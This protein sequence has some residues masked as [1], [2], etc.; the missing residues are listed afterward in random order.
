M[1]YA[2]LGSYLQDLGV[3]KGVRT[4]KGTK[5]FEKIQIIHEDFRES[6]EGMSYESVGRVLMALIAYAND[7]DVS[8]ILGDDVQAKTLFPTIKKHVERNEGYRSKCAENGKKG[9]APF[10]NQNATKNNQKQ[11]KLTKNNQKQTPNLTLPNLTNNNIPT[12]YK[13]NQFTAGM[14][15]Q[16]YD[17]KKLEDKKVRN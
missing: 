7:E 17:F 6:F 3:K 5:M 13:P 16:D 1:E 15:V 10:G 9:G 11:P 2:V 12:V 8:E 14:L 4:T